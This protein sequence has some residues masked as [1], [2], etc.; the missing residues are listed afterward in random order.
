MFI[1]FFERY[2]N[3]SH[4]VNNALLGISMKKLL[5]LSLV[6]FFIFQTEAMEQK[7]KGKRKRIRVANKDLAQYEIIAIKEKRS[8]LIDAGDLH[9]LVPNEVPHEKKLHMEILESP[10][11]SSQFKKS[12]SATVRTLQKDAEKSKQ[13]N[14]KI[15]DKPLPEEF[16][17]PFSE[18]FLA[19]IRKANE[20]RERKDKALQQEQR[21]LENADLS[22]EEGNE[23]STAGNS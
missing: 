20:E 9:K 12:F 2:D 7:N 10:M 3:I 22:D 13:L 1:G 16:K 8:K 19:A 15:K 17:K 4:E 14:L 6:S 11:R 21:D 23:D 18:D 5:L